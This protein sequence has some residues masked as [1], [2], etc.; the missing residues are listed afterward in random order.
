MDATL[1][2]TA[3]EEE[4]HLREVLEQLHGCL[5]EEQSVEGMFSE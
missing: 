2:I 4:E 5:G 1:T 3:V